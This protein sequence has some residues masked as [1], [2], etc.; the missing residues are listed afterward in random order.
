M[1]DLNRNNALSDDQVQDSLLILNDEINANFD[2][3]AALPILITS[4]VLYH[5]IDFW[6]QM[7][8][9]SKTTSIVEFIREKADEDISA[10]ISSLFSARGCLGFGP[11]ALECYVYAILLSATFASWMAC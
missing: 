11:L 2:E 5:S 8:N 9:Q 1:L 7:N 10:G 3:E 6:G 4:S